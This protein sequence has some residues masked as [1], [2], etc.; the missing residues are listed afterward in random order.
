M[1]ILSHASRPVH[2]IYEILQVF[3]ILDIKLASDLLI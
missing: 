1:P 3:N 2:G